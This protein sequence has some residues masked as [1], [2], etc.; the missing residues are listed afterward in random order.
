MAPSPG[1]AD[2]WMAAVPSWKEG[3]TTTALDFDAQG[4]VSGAGSTELLVS[5]PLVDW[6]D[7]SMY[8]DINSHDWSPDGTQLVYD[9]S[10]G[11]IVIADLL[12]GTFDEI[13]M[14]GRW[15]LR[16]GRPPATN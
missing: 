15:I 3:S 1:S 8:P 7:G 13:V 12:T 10:G 16:S 14:Q 5:L 2:A 4:N 9:T 6:G 11:Q